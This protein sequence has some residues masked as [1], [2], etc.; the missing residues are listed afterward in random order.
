MDY[1]YEVEQRAMPF[2]LKVLLSKKDG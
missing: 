2:G 1:K